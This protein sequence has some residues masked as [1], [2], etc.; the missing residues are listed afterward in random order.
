[1]LRIASVFIPATPYAKRKPS[2]LLSSSGIFKT[3]AV[4]KLN[5]APS[6]ALKVRDFTQI[7]S[8]VAQ[9]K[10]KLTK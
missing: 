7:T 5:Y 8:A 2:A 4:R 10:L 1:M 3:A 9:M 6:P